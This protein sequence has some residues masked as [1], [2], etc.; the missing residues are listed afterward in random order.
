MKNIL[1]VYFSP[2]GTTEKIIKAIA[3][4][5]GAEAGSGNVS[6]T[7]MNVTTKKFGQTA[8]TLT[9]AVNDAI[10]SADMV[11]FG[12]PVYANKLP[13]LFLEMA[14]GFTREG[15]EPLP[16]VCIAVYG[17]VNKGYA[18]TQMRDMFHKRGFITIAS[19]AFVGEHSFSHEGYEIAKGRPD[20][21]DLIKAKTFGSEIYHLCKYH[22]DT[23]EAFKS[24]Q[25]PYEEVPASLEKPEKASERT[26]NPFVET[27][28]I[29]KSLCN[30]CGMCIYK[31]PPGAIDRVSYDISEDKCIKCFACV[32][33]CAKKARKITLRNEELFRNR[34]MLKGEKRREP[35]WYTG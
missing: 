35:E 16:C 15:E 6:I 13:D 12:A 28:V 24:V 22:K 9:G 7:E 10:G 30:S 18:Q 17:N 21:E 31:C 2:S 23:G 34:L 8:H 25:L 27:P 5:Y 33:V 26:I 3:E 1:L 19:G 11:I 14:E 4:G 32:R 29:D 20:E